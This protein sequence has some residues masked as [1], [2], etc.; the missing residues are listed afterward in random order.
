MD[1]GGDGDSGWDAVARGL[2][3]DLLGPGPGSGTQGGLDEWLVCQW[4]RHASGA[5]PIT[6]RG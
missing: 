5:V 1:D 2:G 6:A 4:E 3:D